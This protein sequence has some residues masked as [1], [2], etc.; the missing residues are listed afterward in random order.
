MALSK[1][2]ANLKTVSS[3][4]I[5]VCGKKFFGGAG[6]CRVLPIFRRSITQ[7]S[8]KKSRNFRPDHSRLALFEV[9]K[10]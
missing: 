2:I 8:G 7:F 6:G 3:R 4:L 10:V 9:K 5:R 1:L